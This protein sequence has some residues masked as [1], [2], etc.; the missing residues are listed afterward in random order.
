[1]MSIN[2]IENHNNYAIIKDKEFEKI[3]DEFF[4]ILWNEDNEIIESD[5][6]DIIDRI[7]KNIDVYKNYK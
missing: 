6:I 5:K 3:C 2:P 4:E 1:M 7:R